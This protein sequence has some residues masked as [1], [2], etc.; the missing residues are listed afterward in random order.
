MPGRWRDLSHKGRVKLR[1]Y[2]PTK[3]PFE[4]REIFLRLGL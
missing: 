4:L 1:S 2:P 3:F